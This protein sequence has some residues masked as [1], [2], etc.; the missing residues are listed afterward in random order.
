LDAI[1]DS[2]D[3]SLSKLQ[4]MVMEK[5]A[6]LVMLVTASQHNGVTEE[7]YIYMS[8]YICVCVYSHIYIIIYVFIYM[9]IID[10]FCYYLT[11]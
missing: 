4:E 8:I 11:L 7:Q 5:E 2:T 6:W 1:T 9:V 3:M 10:F